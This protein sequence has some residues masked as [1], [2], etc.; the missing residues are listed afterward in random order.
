MIQDQSFIVNKQMNLKGGSVPNNMT[1]IPNNVVIS[2]KSLRNWIEPWDVRCF[3]D[4]CRVVLSEVDLFPWRR[5]DRV[6]IL[7]LDLILS[8]VIQNTTDFQVPMMLMTCTAAT[9]S[10][11]L[12]TYHVYMRNHMFTSYCSILY[13]LILQ[14]FPEFGNLKLLRKIRMCK[15]THTRHRDR[16]T[17]I[18]WWSA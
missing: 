11:H 8:T 16:L 5:L 9:F 3:S 7:N 2:E 1:L 10:T 6:L 13:Y 12:Q 18:A 15:C 17:A 14:I 4:R